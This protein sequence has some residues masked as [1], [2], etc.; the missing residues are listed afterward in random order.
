VR[1]RPAVKVRS[2]DP[3]PDAIDPSLARRI[4]ALEGSTAQLRR[5]I[6]LQ[7]ERLDWALNQLDGV[8]TLTE[9]YHAYRA[10]PAYQEVFEVDT[11][12]VSV[13]VA[14]MDRAEVLVERAVASILCQSYRHLE[15]IVVGDDCR[16]DTAQRLSRL[17]DD[18][19]TF[20]DL[21]QRGPYPPPGT[22]RWRVAGTV[23]MNHALSLAR[24]HFVTH[25]DDD[26][27]MTPERI[28][29]L[30]AAALEDR[31]DFLWHDFWLETSTGSWRRVGG[32]VLK[33]GDVTTGSVFYHRF[34]A[35]IP[36]SIE[37]FRS[38]EPG[39]WNRFRKIKALAPRTR[40]VPEALLYHHREK[41]QAFVERPGE[42][43]L[44]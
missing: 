25:L 31:A 9:Q 27:A 42:R 11:P 20:V 23:P 28:E 19:I 36:W 35:R 22:D 12:L 10:K 7:G 44:E 8:P 13:C 18:R 15:V 5:H 41:D 32:A 40:Y 14:T 39:D 34:F 17:G 33:S 6:D 4:A 24:G 29:T 2:A 43:Y 26:D 16:D 30:V 3:P 1:S 37:A 38:A 21:P